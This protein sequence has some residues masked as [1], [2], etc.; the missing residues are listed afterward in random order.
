VAGGR[1]EIVGLWGQ[2]CWQLNAKKSVTYG[3]AKEKRGK[4]KAP[5]REGTPAVAEAGRNPRGNQT[6]DRMEMKCSRRAI[7]NNR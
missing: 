5:E 2:G 7:A 6:K 4:K 3:V 1:E